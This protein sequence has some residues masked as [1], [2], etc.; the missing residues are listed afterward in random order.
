[1]KIRTQQIIDSARITLADPRKERWSDDDL[2]ALLQEGQHDFCLQTEMLSGN[3]YIYLKAG[4]PSF[5][6]PADCW[7]LTRVLN[8]G[9]KLPFLTHYDMDSRYGTYNGPFDQASGKTWETDIGLPKALVYDRRNPTVCRVYPIPEESANEAP[10][11]SVTA[12]SGSPYIVDTYGVAESITGFILEPIFGVIADGDV[13]GVIS[14]ASQ[15]V[16]PN[17]TPIP[18]EE[19]ED[20]VLRIGYTRLPTTALSLDEELLETPMSYDIALKFYVAGQALLNDLDAQYQQ[21]GAQQLSIYDRHVA[22]AKRDSASDFARA[23]LLTTSY[24]KG[25]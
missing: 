23:H 13:F 18:E 25:V 3:A 10:V 1:M 5:A 7:R 4:E 14:D 6:L 20:Y 12:T 22:K 9:N 11:A 17:D 8:A 15:L 24:R 19:S 2:L 21:K 16:N